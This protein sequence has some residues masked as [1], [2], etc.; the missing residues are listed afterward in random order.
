[1]I[2]RHHIHK[3]DAP[4][5][6]AKTLAS[7]LKRPIE[8]ESVREGEIIGEHEIILESEYER[9]IVM[10]T[11][12]DR[13][14]F[15]AG[16]L[17]FAKWLPTQSNGLYTG[18]EKKQLKFAKYQGCGNDFIFI[19]NKSFPPS[20]DKKEFVTKYCT[21]GTSIGADGVIF[22][23]KRDKEVYWEYFNSD[24]SLVAM[25]GNGARCVGAYAF[26]QGWDCDHLRNSHNVVQRF[27]LEDGLVCVEMPTAVAEEIPT[28]ITDLAK[29]DS[30]KAFKFGAFYT[31]GV[32]H[33]IF[34]SESEGF[35]TFSPNTIGEAVRN[36]IDVNTN[37]FTRVA[38]NALKIRT[39]E[40]GVY[41]ETLACGS[42]C[43]AVAYHLWKTH[44]SGKSDKYTL[45]VRSGLTITVRLEEDGTI[46]LSGPTSKVFDGVLEDF[47][48]GALLQ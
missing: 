2:E 22:V 45:Q 32:P 30:L 34:E 7:Y 1:M 43:C 25:C 39:Y 24:G 14:I 40:R 9:M 27:M 8:I 28:G 44:N 19:D 15:A 10:H 41:G 13:A 31:V 12:K 33:V 26:H 17:R 18:M 37:I 29:D 3:K 11:A 21:R 48:T 35:D 20:L 46:F 23:E 38:P 6:T 42:G 47:W 5:G 36:V 4:S 16:A